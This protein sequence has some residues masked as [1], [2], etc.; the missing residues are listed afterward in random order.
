MKNEFEFSRYG[1]AIRSWWAALLLGLVFI[2]AGVIVFANPGESYLALSLMFGVMVIV[3]G[4][5][6]I[7]VGA[8]APPRSG[9]GWLIAAGIIELLLGILMMIVP[10]MLLAILPFVLGFWL[11]F[12]GFTM[13]GLSSDMMDH[14]VKNAGWILFLAILLILCSFAVL[15]NPV[16][17]IGALVIWLGISLVLAGV[18]LITYSVYLF[19]LKKFLNK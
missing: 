16:I 8:I 1:S 12:R 14:G 11:M 5:I 4:V 10:T 15:I 18:V 2:A 17:G 19:R 3:S 6:E 9:R 7:Y 13:V